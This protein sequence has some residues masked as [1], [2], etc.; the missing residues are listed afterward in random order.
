MKT[1]VIFAA[2]ILFMIV[3]FVLA[4]GLKSYSLFLIFVFIAFVGNVVTELVI[5]RLK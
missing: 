4:F 3:C 2:N 1:E 5:N